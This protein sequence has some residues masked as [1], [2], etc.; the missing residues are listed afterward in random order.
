MRFSDLLTATPT[1]IL[2]N[3]SLRIVRIDKISSFNPEAKHRLEEKEV[4]IS[5]SIGTKAEVALSALSAPLVPLDQP[6]ADGKRY[7]EAGATE[8]AS[9]LECY[10]AD[11]AGPWIRRHGVL[12]AHFPQLK[13]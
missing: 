11:P 7:T 4:K 10:V 6:F 3:P 5:S 12:I 13:T 1:V 9:R 2:T 8:V